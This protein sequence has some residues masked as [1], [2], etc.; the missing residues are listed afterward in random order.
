MSDIEPSETTVAGRRTTSEKFSQDVVE[1]PPQN[2]APTKTEREGL[3][4]GYRMRADPHYVEQLTSRRAEKAERV[5]AAAR[6]AAAPATE[7]SGVAHEPDPS[8]RRTERVLAQLQEEIATIAAAVGFLSTETSPLARRLNLDLIRAQAWRA[9]W[10]VRAHALVEGRDRSQLRSKTLGSFLE[11]IRLG[12]TPE[13][14]LAG[15]TLQV[16]ASDWN[17][18]VS[19]DESALGAGITGSVIATL[20]FLGQAEGAKIR[21]AVDTAGSDLRSIEVTQDDVAVSQ[22]AV[23]RF[24]DLSWAERPGGWTAG[25]GAL[26]ARAAAQQHGGSALLVV[27]DRRGTAV[28][29]NLARTH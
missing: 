15:V 28:K 21:I 5:D 6:G 12:L 8:E 3:P 26:T 24:F 19:V 10:L 4:G 11:Q 17:A 16:H 18:S 7:P 1:A 25:L 29:M 22:A 2:V 9:S 13:C 20:G 27:G 23:L 14:R